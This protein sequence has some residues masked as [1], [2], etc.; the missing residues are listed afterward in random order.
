MRSASPGVEL[1]RRE[2]LERL[3]EK[4]RTLCQL[5]QAGISDANADEKAT[6]KQLAQQFPGA[7]RELDSFPTEELEKRR[8]QIAR[9]LK[10]GEAEPWMEWMASYHALMRVAL[11]IR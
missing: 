1:E 5:R 9:A 8:D 11:A 4:Y 7:L 2:E 3:H 6:L 10:S